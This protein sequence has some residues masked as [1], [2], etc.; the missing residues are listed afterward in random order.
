MKSRKNLYSTISII[1]ISTLIFGGCNKKGDDNINF[2]EVESEIKAFYSML[3]GHV[4]NK[5]VEEWDRYF[6][7]S[8][9]IGNIHNNHPQ[10]GWELFHKGIVELFSGN[11]DGN[12]TLTEFKIHPIDNRLIWVSALWTWEFQDGEILKSKFYDTLIKTDDGW[13]VV[14]SVVND[15]DS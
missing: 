9:N 4:K 15:I 13:R 3:E 2:T 6:L 11:L 5:T 10:V 8:P 14:V 12:M 1:L 7:K